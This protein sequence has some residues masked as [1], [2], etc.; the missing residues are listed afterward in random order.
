[1]KKR[2]VCFVGILLLAL[3]GGALAFFCL[4]PGPE[5]AA[6]AAVRQALACTRAQARQWEQLLADPAAADD[7]AG[8]P[9]HAAGVQIGDYRD[10][11]CHP[12]ILNHQMVDAA[13]EQDKQ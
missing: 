4:R 12:L 2:T 5:K 6:E 9:V 11:R 10:A 1:M 3:A 8:A 13:A 7:A